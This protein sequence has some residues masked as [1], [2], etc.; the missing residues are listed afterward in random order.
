MGQVPQPIMLKAVKEVIEDGK[1]IRKT[2]NDYGLS[3]SALCRY[4]KKYKTNPDCSLTPNYKHSNVFTHEKEQ[5]L[6]DYLQMAS[7]MFFGLTPIKTRQ[8]A[9]EM[10]ERNGLKMPDQ[11]KDKKLAGRTWLTN[12]LKRNPML[13]I[14]SPEATSLAR[15]S[16]FIRHT[17]KVFF[18][19]LEVLIKKL[20]VTGARIFNLDES[21]FTTVQKV[22]KVISVKGQKQVGQITS[23]ERGELVT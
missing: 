3:R 6:V 18:D 9:Y 10:A 19:V 21:G 7:K 5:M 23:R 4:V 16:A 22:P 2:A 14:R 11:W 17:V 15:A 13:S 20:G 12:F 1:T 8:L